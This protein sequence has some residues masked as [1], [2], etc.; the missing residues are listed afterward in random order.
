MIFVMI[1]MMLV[2]LVVIVVMMVLLHLGEK[3]V[4][5]RHRL[6]HRVMNRLPAQ[7]IPRS[8]D[9]RRVRILLTDHADR[10]VD[11]LL[12]C[13][14]CAGQDNR[15]GAL[16]L[17]VVELAEVLH[18][19]LNL[20]HISY[21]DQRSDL[22]IAF[23]RCVFDRAADIG[24]LAHAGWLDDD[25]IRMKLVHDLLQGFRKITD[26]TAAD[27]AGIHL[28]YI[29]S[30][31]LKEPSVDADLS[32]LVLDQDDLLAGKYI[33]DQFLDQCSFSCSEEPGDNVDLCHF[34]PFFP[35]LSRRCWI[36]HCQRISF[37]SACLPEANC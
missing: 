3:L 22:Q 18:I 21:R 35:I 31:F 19:H 28:C 25:V 17:V 10:V 16:D 33:L 24:E 32:E 29:D 27:A 6:F 2:I 36:G 4:G 13:I 1:V 12:R 5:K 15:S 34:L 26:Q 11:L 9:D 23:L 14:L 20:L 8:R 37:E 7:L 30:R